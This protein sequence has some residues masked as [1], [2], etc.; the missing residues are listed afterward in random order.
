MFLIGLLTGSYKF[1]IQILPF[2]MRSTEGFKNRNRNRAINH[3]GSFFG[4]FNSVTHTN[5]VD[6]LAIPFKQSIAHI[7]AYYISFELKFS[8]SFGHDFKNGMV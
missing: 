7:T 4:Q 5:K 3:P 8:R 2:K 1:Q 6:I